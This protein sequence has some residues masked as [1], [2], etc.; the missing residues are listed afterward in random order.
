MI[1][2]E[3]E[4]SFELSRGKLL[5]AAGTVAAAALL[6]GFGEAEAA[7][8][9][10][11][12]RDSVLTPPVHGLHLQFGADASSEMVVSWHTL[13]SVRGPR[14][15]LGHLD[16]KLE[17]T[18]DAEETSSPMQSPVRQSSHITQG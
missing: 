10:D 4:C 8:A 17:R 18:V 6:N 9:V 1:A 14:V 5:A 7:L 15:L 13:Q 16:G 3:M 11:R 2:S 12:S